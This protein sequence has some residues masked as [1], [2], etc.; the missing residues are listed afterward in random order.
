MFT[1]IAVAYSKAVTYN[2]LCEGLFISEM[3]YLEI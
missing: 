2:L 3:Q 1:Q